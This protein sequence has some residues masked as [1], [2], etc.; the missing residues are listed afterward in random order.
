MTENLLSCKCAPGYHQQVPRVLSTQIRM[1]RGS[2]FAELKARPAETV[3]MP[4]SVLAATS[5][6]TCVQLMMS[7]A[8]GAFCVP[9]SRSSRSSNAAIRA[10]PDDAQKTPGAPRRQSQSTQG[11]SLPPVHNPCIG[12]FVVHRRV[13]KTSRR[14]R[15]CRPS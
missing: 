11:L 10:G 15:R 9:A 4:H 14:P 13:S 5:T 2:R 3:R 7:K 12:K 6:T 1:M 8:H